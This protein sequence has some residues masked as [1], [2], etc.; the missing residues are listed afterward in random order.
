LKRNIS[1]KLNENSLW[2]DIFCLF[3]IVV[4]QRGIYA[5]TKFWLKILYIYSSL[6]CLFY[7]EAAGREKFECMNVEYVDII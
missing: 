2:K 1:A 3:E 4:I 5:D 7:V 6:P